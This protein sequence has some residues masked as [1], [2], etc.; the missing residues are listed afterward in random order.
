MTRNEQLLLI[1]SWARSFHGLSLEEAHL[2]AQRVLDD[3]FSGSIS[4]A[5]PIDVMK[6]F[7]KFSF[8]ASANGEI[9]PGDHNVPTYQEFGLVRPPQ[10]EGNNAAVLSDNTVVISEAMADYPLPLTSGGVVPPLS[11]EQRDVIF[12]MVFSDPEGFTQETI[13]ELVENTPSVFVPQSFV[14]Q[15]AVEVYEALKEQAVNNS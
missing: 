3:E 11:D 12:P 2:V 14:E 13:D 1:M 7:D 4:N 15:R 9:L 6:T 5:N 8:T 10:L